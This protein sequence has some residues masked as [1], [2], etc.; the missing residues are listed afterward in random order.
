MRILL[1][2]EYSRL[3]NSLKEGLTKLGHE[4]VIVG[5][6]DGFKNYPVDL[7]LDH[8]FHKPFL[9]K[10]KVA[11]Y[12]LTS[13]DLGSLEIYL[14]AVYKFKKMKGFDVVQLIN[15]SPLVIQ[16]KYEKR[17]IKRLLKHNKKLFL[18]SCGIDH[19]CMKFMMD[20]KFRYSIMSPYLA[21]RSLYKL[22]KF[23]LQ[24]LNSEFTRL[25]HF[26][27]EHANGVIATDMDYHLPLVGHPKY[28]GLIPNAIN[29]EK[30]KYIP[31]TTDG[32]IKIFH[33]VNKSAIVK[34]G[35][36]YFEEALKIIEKKYADKVE[37]K[38]T[39][40]IPYEQYIK[41]YDD[42][43]ILLDQA[44]GYDQGYNA[45]EAM[46][47]GKVVFTG[48]EKEWVKHYGLEKN[49][50][51]INAKPDVNSLVKNLEWLINNPEQIEIISKNARRF[52]EKEHNLLKVT[53]RYLETW[54]NN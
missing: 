43:H 21:D 37:I 5:N 14:K 49:T 12:K 52:I 26:I 40:S 36:I 15:E 29:T 39:Y 48:A 27:Y 22:Y 20:G 38:T 51:A 32:K 18:L 3:H 7:F 19:Q 8:S 4:V 33:G 11:F 1:V 44:Y 17:F 2:G 25:H 54:N 28:L 10:L 13:V 9:R 30:I 6:G 35:N 42:C 23:Q 24:Y 47:K 41:L 16:A 53:K 45:L 31:F 50:V 46:A 34:K